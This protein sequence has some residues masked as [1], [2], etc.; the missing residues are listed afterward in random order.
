MTGA[1]VATIVTGALVVATLLIALTVNDARRL[2]QPPPP[3]VVLFDGTVAGPPLVAHALA[4][5]GRPAAVVRAAAGA[6][7]GPPARA[8]PAPP[9]VSPPPALALAADM[10]VVAEA[11]DVTP[12]RGEIRYRDR[13]L[14]LPLTPALRALALRRLAEVRASDELGPQIARQDPT[15]CRA[16]A[17]RAM[18]AI[19]RVNAPLPHSSLG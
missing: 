2:S 19:G 1:M 17:Y 7:V 15:V 10:L 12:A 3:E 14:A 8:G 18:C 16:C 11:L 9:G 5:S 4:L 13:A 6:V